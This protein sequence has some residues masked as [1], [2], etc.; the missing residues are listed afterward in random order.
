MFFKGK[1]W[2]DKED[3]TVSQKRLQFIWF[4]EN[5]YRLDYCKTKKVK[6]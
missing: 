5:D 2:I 6:I 1:T 3:I 4:L